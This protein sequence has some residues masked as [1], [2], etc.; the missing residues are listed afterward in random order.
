MFV[1]LWR[2][3]RRSAPASR[4]L[5]RLLLRLRGGGRSTEARH[6]GVAAL[7]RLGPADLEHAVLAE[8]PGEVLQEIAVATVGVL[9]QRVAARLTGDELPEF[10]GGVDLFPRCADGRA[11]P[12]Q[13]AVGEPGDA[14]VY[15]TLPS[16]AP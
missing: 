14:P 7:E 12:T 13:A 9:R 3:M 10:H 8:G 6:D 15:P 16:P 2:T 1:T 5:R 11:D 4:C